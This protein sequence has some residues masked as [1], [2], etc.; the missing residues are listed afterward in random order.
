M[1]FI[2]GAL[3]VLF[4]HY[5]IS[6]SSFTFTLDDDSVGYEQPGATIMIW[7][8]LK[9]PYASDVILEVIRIQNDLPVGWLSTICTD[10]C[11]PATQDTSYL[12]LVAGDSSYFD[13]SFYTTSIDTGYATVLFRNI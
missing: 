9:N 12:E 7:G 6:Q 5:G 1:K 10:I 8:E 4:S 3:M 2:I 11:Y 13:F